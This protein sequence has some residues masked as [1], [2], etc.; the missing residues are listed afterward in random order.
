MPIPTGFDNKVIRVTASPVTA[1]DLNTEIAAQNGDDFYMTN[2]MFTDA[3]NAFLLFAK[4]LGGTGTT[5][6]QKVN[7]V[8]Q[9]Q[10]ALDADKATEEGN[11]NFPTGL[12]VTPGGGLLVFYQQLILLH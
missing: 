7:E 8:T 2:L 3:N 9:T 11:G 1:S 5:W 12:F 6:S 10:A 4:N